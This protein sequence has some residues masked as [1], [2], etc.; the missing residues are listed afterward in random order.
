MQFAFDLNQA[1]VKIPALLTANLKKDPSKFID[2]Q[3]ELRRMLA[4]L[5]SQG[6]QLFLTSNSP[7]ELMELIM[8]ATLGH[9]WSN[10]FDLSVAN[11]R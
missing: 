6:K 8:D 7:L 5:R 4:I 10:F 2:H 9:S 11:A 3:P 1:R